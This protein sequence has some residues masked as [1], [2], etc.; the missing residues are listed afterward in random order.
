MKKV[1]KV[2]QDEL[3][4]PSYTYGH[5]PKYRTACRRAATKMKVTTDMARVTCQ[6]CKPPSRHNPVATQ[7]LSL[8]T[9]ARLRQEFPEGIPHWMIAQNLTEESI[10]KAML[11]RR[12]AF[13][14]TEVKNEN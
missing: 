4:N 5:T 14:K 7:P 6:Y 12:L 9:M 13:P 1:H 3:D 2:T 10:R 8:E 11:L